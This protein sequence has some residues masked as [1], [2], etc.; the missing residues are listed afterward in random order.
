MYHY[1]NVV[2]FLSIN[3]MIAHCQHELGNIGILFKF[4][5]FFFFF[6]GGGGGGGGGTNPTDISEKMR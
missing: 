1:K 4:V 3:Y 5:F 2:Y 6:L